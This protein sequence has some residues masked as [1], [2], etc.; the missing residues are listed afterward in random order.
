MDD[1]KI[2]Y[3]VLGLPENA[4]KQQIENRYYV[5]VRKD[6]TRTLRNEHDEG[7][8]STFN[9]GEVNQAYKMI[10]E[11]EHERMRAEYRQK[12]YARSKD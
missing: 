6:R 1:L 9:I 8:D 3:E 5:L 2:A 4:T 11:F 12:H 7:P 10:M